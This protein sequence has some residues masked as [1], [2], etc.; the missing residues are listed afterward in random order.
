MSK[1]YI[2]TF[3]EG[4]LISLMPINS[5]HVHLYVKWIN[6]PKVRLYSRSVVPRTIEEWK[7]LFLNMPE[8]RIKTHIFFE[9]WHKKDKKPLGDVGLFDINWFDKKA[10]IGLLIGEK[11]YWNKGIGTEAI[12][13]TTNYGFKE[14]NLN[15]LYATVYAPNKASCRC[16]E[17]NHFIKEAILKNDTFIENK[18]LDLYFYSILKEFWLK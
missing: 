8:E 10:F 12:K 1:P 7:K 3:I 5:D 15:K 13:L 16:F 11:E 18:Y 2:Y 6:D 14:L 9:I 17:K 4:E